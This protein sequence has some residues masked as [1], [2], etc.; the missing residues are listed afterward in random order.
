MRDID[1][2][3]PELAV[4]LPDGRTL[5]FRG[6]ID[7]VDR[8]VDGLLVLDYK[9]GKGKAYD[10]ITAADPFV[11]GTKLQ[12]PLYALAARRTFDAPHAEAHYLLLERNGERRGYRVDDAVVSQFTEVLTDIT[13]GIEQGVFLARPGP[14]DSF[15]GTH[16]AC[17]Y[18]DFD[19]L[20]SPQ[21]G[22]HWDTKTAVPPPGSPLARYRRLAGL[23]AA[24]APAP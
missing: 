22:E 20:C 16:Q 12:L 15:F 21:R 6:V 5:T 19:R 1:D 13:D 10:A 11:G 23:D 24:E 17:R 18:C 8:T 4:T 14:Y 2:A 9:T 3:G 7:R